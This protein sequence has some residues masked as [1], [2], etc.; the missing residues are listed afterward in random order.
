MSR[1]PAT[2]EAGRPIVAELGRPETPDETAD[3]KAASRVA[4]RSNQ[5]TLNLVIALIASLLVGGIL[6][7]SWVSRPTVSQLEP[8]DYR[9]VAADAQRSIDVPLV[10]P[11]LPPGWTA[12][13]AE[14]VPATTDGVDSWQIGLLTP[15]GQYI[16]LV[17][18]MAVD[19]T[20]VNAS[21]VSDQTARAEATDK[22]LIG[23]TDWNVYDR[24]DADDTGNLA[25]ALVAA[26]GD[27]TVVL[28]GTATDDEFATLAESVATELSK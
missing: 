26:F 22:L 24:R 19:G 2:D 28:G 18:G 13:R 15:S 17:Q 20:G 6:V 1:Q 8:V 4:R 9:A 23:D 25:Y 27:S 14:F 12:N 7:F 5:T 21:W 16:G 11:T 3:R 10:V